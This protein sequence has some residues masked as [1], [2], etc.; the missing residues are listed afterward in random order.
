M[1]M[2][3]YM[4]MS[5]CELCVP[6]CVLYEYGV[7]VGVLCSVNIC[8]SPSPYACPRAVCAWECDRPCGCPL[9]ARGWLLLPGPAR[10]GAGGAG[11]DRGG[12]GW[13]NWGMGWGGQ[14]LL[15]FHSS[16]NPAPHWCPGT[17]GQG[18]WGR[19]PPPLAKTPW[20][21]GMC[22]HSPRPGPTAHP[23]L[24]GKESA[25]PAWGRGCLDGA[26]IVPSEGGESVEGEGLGAPGPLGRGWG[27][28]VGAQQK[29]E[30]S[31]WARA[32]RPPLQG[33]GPG[34]GASESWR[35]GEGAGL[36]SGERGAG[37]CYSSGSNANSGSCS[38]PAW[39]VFSQFRAPRTSR[40]LPA[41]LPAAPPGLRVVGGRGWGFCTGG[42]VPA[43]GALELQ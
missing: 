9:A 26:A 7:S 41:P 10:C 20:G 31:T 11:A 3:D 37:L 24:S 39:E 27:C 40:P 5:M 38:A 13:G 8:T 6:Q 17:L 34:P 18:C 30:R 25:R 2:C 14:S 21:G 35:P 15:H 29:P 4:C 22:P 16:W 33:R 12:R 32:P 1:S 19:V 43:L 23:A 42:G 36:G 28:G